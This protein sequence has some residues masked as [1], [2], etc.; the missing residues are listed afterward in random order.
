LHAVVQPRRP[1][2]HQ[3]AMRAHAG[4]LADRRA[5]PRQ[6]ARRS[7]AAP[8]GARDG[9]AGWPWGGASERLRVS[10]ETEPGREAASGPLQDWEPVIGLEVHVQ[11][12]TKSK[13]FSPSANAF[14][15]SPNS[16]TDPLVL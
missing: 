5:A 15:E 2:R 6:A 3:R 4:R 1:A 8:R 7:H 14:G 11:L 12:G 9:D 13:A 10:P 16:L